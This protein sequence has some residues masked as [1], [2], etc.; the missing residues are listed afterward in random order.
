MFLFALRKSTRFIISVSNASVPDT[1]DCSDV[2]PFVSFFVL[3][4]LL[5]SG[6]ICSFSIVF[7]FEIPLNLVDN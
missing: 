4:D 6:E 5:K 3:V 1:S 7:V 2:A